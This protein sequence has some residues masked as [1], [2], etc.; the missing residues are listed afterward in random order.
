M[1]ERISRKKATDLENRALV[2]ASQKLKTQQTALSRKLHEI[3]QKQTN[4]TLP[5]VNAKF[6][7]QLQQKTNQMRDQ[8]RAALD[9]AL[10]RAEKGIEKTEMTEEEKKA[11]ADSKMKAFLLNL[12]AGNAILR[13]KAGKAEKR[14][15]SENP[16]ASVKTKLMQQLMRNETQPRAEDVH[17][18]IMKRLKQKLRNNLNPPL[19]QKGTEHKRFHKR[20]HRNT[21]SSEERK[22]SP[23][24]NYMRKLANPP[25][26]RP[27]ISKSPLSNVHNT[28]NGNQVRGLKRKGIDVKALLNQTRARLSG[29]KVNITM[30]PKGITR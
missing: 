30:H 7:Q 11:Q 28:S 22:A 17:K 15:E 1:H 16:S 27:V 23:N 6:A 20:T 10:A 26:M 4:Q 19:K 12:V 8:A 21:L 18:M 25:M 29:A 24:L 2:Q 9:Y 5:L 13:N 14:V 3:A